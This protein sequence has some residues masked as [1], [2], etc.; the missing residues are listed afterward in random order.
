MAHDARRPQSF[1]STSAVGTLVLLFLT[2]LVISF[3]SVKYGIERGLVYGSVDDSVYSK[4][5]DVVCGIVYGI[6]YFTATA[7]PHVV[8]I[9][10][11]LCQ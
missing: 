8:Y 2:L 9:L 10:M 5:Y 4:V 1:S 11:L 7:C 6:V 3:W